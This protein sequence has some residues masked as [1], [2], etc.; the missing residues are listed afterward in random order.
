MRYLYSK[1][2]LTDSIPRGTKKKLAEEEDQSPVSDIY[3]Q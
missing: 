2:H 3:V 1:A